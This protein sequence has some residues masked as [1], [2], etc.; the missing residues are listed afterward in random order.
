MQ[1]EKKLVEKILAELNIKIIKNLMKNE[2]FDIE[3]FL[4]KVIKTNNID[5]IDEVFDILICKNVKNK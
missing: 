5:N 3:E 4:K 2:K 1:I